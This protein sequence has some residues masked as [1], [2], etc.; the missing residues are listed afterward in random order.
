MSLVPFESAVTAGINKHVA[1]VGTNGS[2]SLLW[3]HPPP[4]VMCC[5]RYLSLC[6]SDSKV[7]SAHQVRAASLEMPGFFGYV[8]YIVRQHF[9]MQLHIQMRVAITVPCMSVKGKGT[10]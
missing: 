8:K 7:M 1:S 9:G 5:V 10:A 2:V 6:E 3:S 4:V